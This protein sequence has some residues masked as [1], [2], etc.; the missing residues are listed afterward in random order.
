MW[1]AQEVDASNSLCELFKSQRK[2]SV[3]PSVW[4]GK[5]YTSNKEVEFVVNSLVPEVGN[6]ADESRLQAV[7]NTRRQSKT[8]FHYARNGDHL[9]VP[10]DCDFCIFAKLSGSSG[11]AVNTDKDALMLACI[12]RAYLD[13]FWSRVASTVVANGDRVRASLVLS[14]AVGLHRPYNSQG[15]L[16]HFDCCGYKVAIQMLLASRKPGRYS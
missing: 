6:E 9:M 2:L 10:F 13:A 5:F 4:C 8:E 16:T 11:R 1:N 7:W 12:R 3:M 14:E 15:N